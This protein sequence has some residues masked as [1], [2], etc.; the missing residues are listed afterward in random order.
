MHI[1]I[2]PLEKGG[3]ILSFYWN[4]TQ[5]NKFFRTQQEIYAYLEI[6][7]EIGDPDKAYLR[8]NP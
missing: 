5:R 3:F 8:M 7:S 4:G 6:L 2:Q 1:E